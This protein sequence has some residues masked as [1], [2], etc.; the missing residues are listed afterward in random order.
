MAECCSQQGGKARSFWAEAGLYTLG[1]GLCVG[2]HVG[3]RARAV[4]HL[5]EEVG[6]GGCERS[7]E[8]RERRGGG[9][10]WLRKVVGEARVEGQEGRGERGGE[11]WEG[12]EESG[13][14]GG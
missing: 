2:Q 3:M 11:S 8:R 7:W 5:R 6:G 12:R 14:V 9:R 1:E 4:R 10:S 13:E